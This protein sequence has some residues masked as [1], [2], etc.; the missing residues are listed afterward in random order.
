MY[1]RGEAYYAKNDFGRAAQEFEAVVARFSTGA[2]V[3]D[4]MLKLGMCHERLGDVARARED[5][6]RL[7]NEYPRSSA[8]TKIPSGTTESASKGSKE[9]R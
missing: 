8:A 5:F 2:K 9:N 1:W 4:A 3:P 6:Q 7:R